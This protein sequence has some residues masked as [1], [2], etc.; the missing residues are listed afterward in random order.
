M[1][2]KSYFIVGN[3]RA[4]QGVGEVKDPPFSQ[5]AQSTQK[6]K[7]KER[8]ISSRFEKLR[9]QTKFALW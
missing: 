1:E 3:I 5:L 2:W 9:P 7:E 4:L 6:K 8:K